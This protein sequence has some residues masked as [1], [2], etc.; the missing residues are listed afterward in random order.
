MVLFVHPIRYINIPAQKSLATPLLLLSVQNYFDYLQSGG[1]SSSSGGSLINGSQGDL[2]PDRLHSP[3]LLHNSSFNSGQRPN[4]SF[5]SGHRLIMAS[6][7]N[8]T[9]DP[10][11][12]GLNR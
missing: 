1:T 7:P 4:S 12:S 11:A 9:L 8:L 6:T 10:M 2:S 3:I 5:N